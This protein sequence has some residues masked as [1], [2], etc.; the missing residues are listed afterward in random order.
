MTKLRHIDGLNTARFVTFSCFHRYHLLRN[1]G[2]IE[3]FLAVVDEIRNA[4]GLL[5]YGYV[6]MPNHIHLVLWPPN[7]LQLG[8]VI[9][10]L[11][12][13]AARRILARV[14]LERLFLIDRLL[15]G[16]GEKTSVSFWQR[17]CYDHNCRTP[18]T[19][20]EK[21][22]YCH[23][24]PVV[25]KLVSEPGQWQWSS[26]NWYIGKRDVPIRIDTFEY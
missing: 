2:V 9:G 6:I 7:D 18:E 25:R 21:I 22:E 13:R 10:E 15:H 16:T 24:N 3:D 12:S 5:L 23:D 17:R 4:R 19:V 26:Y 14:R 8:R 1:A 11:K 20:R